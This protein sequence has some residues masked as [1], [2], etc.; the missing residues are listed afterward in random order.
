MM[1]MGPSSD[2]QIEGTLFLGGGPAG[3]GTAAVFFPTG[4]VSDVV[5]RNNTIDHLG[6]LQ[7]STFP[8]RSLVTQG[9]GSVERLLFADNLNRQ[10]GPG[11][12]EEQN[13]GEQILFETGAW[14]GACIVHE[15]APDR[16]SIKV[17]WVLSAARP[18]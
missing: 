16:L 8:G 10:A 18:G 17:G 11:G 13:Q 15:V 6:P 3:G 9:T 4:Y 5:F 7:S 2:I 14:S 1:V 12:N